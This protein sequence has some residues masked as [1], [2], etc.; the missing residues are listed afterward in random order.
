MKGGKFYTINGGSV[1]VSDNGTDWTTVAT[2]DMKQLVAA[3]TAH[4]YALSS[5]NKLMSSADD[6]ATW[7]EE[8]LD[9]D[10][11]LLPTEDIAF[12]CHKLKTNDNTDKLMIIGN[13]NA[14]DFPDD[15]TAMVWTKVDEY[16]DGARKNAWNYVEFSSDNTW[17]APRVHNWQTV[18]YDGN[19]IKAI[20]GNSLDGL[21]KALSQ[22]YQSGDDGITWLNDSVMSVPSDLSSSETA[23]T[24]VAD[25][26]N[27]VW[28]I[29]GGTGQ[30]WKGRIN[31]VAW[32]EEQKYFKE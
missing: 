9:D 28:I 26:V 25:G 27:S 6:G 20:A 5:G 8:S 31:R 17:K 21:K 3:S 10:A 23:F 24:M 4:I 29:C 12:T 30:V 15:N 14:T 18:I 1:I 13:R 11:A 19:N 32:R 7:T 22:I 16:S 2:T